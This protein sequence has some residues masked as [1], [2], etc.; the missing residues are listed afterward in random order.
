MKRR[1]YRIPKA[2]SMNN[3]KLITEDLPAPE[4]DEALIRVHAIGLN[5]AD[6]FALQGLYS[7]T[8]DGSFIPGLEFA[9]EVVDAGNAVSGVSPGAKVMGVTRFGAYADHVKLN[10]DYIV[11][12]PAGWSYAEGAAFSVQAL[13]A[14]YALVTLGNMQPDSKVLIH[15]AAGGVGIWANRIAKKTGGFTIG[16]VGLEEKFALLKSEGYDLW[17]VRSADFKAQ[18]MKLTGN[19]KPDLILECIGGRIFNDSYEILNQQG[20]LISYGA[21]HFG[22]KSPRPDLLTSMW[23]YLTRPK[24]DPMEMMKSNKSVMAFNLIWLFDKKHLFHKLIGELIDLDL[25]RP[26]VKHTF[27]FENMHEALRLFQTG[28]TTGKVIVEV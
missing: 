13:T 19:V 25:G 27:G 9:G 12:L 24:I 20:R 17:M 7:A 5:F 21:A 8:P 14:Y 2:G 18:L 28:K 3:L 6:I 22:N 4:A 16:V 1:V 11:E 10:S 15:S 26:L 23:K